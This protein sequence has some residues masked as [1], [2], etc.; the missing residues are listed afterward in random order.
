MLE[1]LVV[2]V[3]RRWDDWL[4][5]HA[6]RFAGIR[7]EDAEPKERRLSLDFKWLWRKLKRRI[8]G[9]IVMFAGLSP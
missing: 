2:F 7:P 3:S 8:R 6:S 1:A 4:S 9:S 5:F